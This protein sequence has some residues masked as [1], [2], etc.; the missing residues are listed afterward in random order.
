[1]TPTSQDLYY[2][3][4]YESVQRSADEWLPGYEITEV[5]RRKTDNTYWQLSYLVP[6]EKVNRRKLKE[7]CLNIFQVN[8][9][10]K[11]VITYEPVLK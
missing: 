6:T 2:D 9:V 7:D 8:P 11:T 10:E 1:M 3:H 4:D 5:F